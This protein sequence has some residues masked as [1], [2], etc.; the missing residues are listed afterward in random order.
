MKEL[1][2]NRCAFAACHRAFGGVWLVCVLHPCLRRTRGRQARPHEKTGLSILVRVVFAGTPEFAL[3]CLQALLAAEDVE[4]VGVVTQPDRRAGRGLRMLPSP[5]KR[6]ARAAGVEVITPRSLHGNPE[7]RAWLQGKRPD[8]LVVVAYGLLLPRAWLEAPRIAPINV[9]A[10]LLPR[11]RGAAPIERALLAGDAETGV[12]IMRMEE[13]LDCGGIY[14]RCRVAI[15]ETTT[16]AELR[17]ILAAAGAEL[18]IDSLPRILAGELQPEPQDESQATYAAKITAADRLIDWSEPAA[19]VDQRV[20]CFS[21]SPGA[22]TRL[23]GRW[24]KILRG[25][26][27]PD[28]IEG[29][30]PGE[31]VDSKRLVVVCGDRRLYRLRIVQPEGKKA[32]DAAAFVRG[33]ALSPESCFKSGAG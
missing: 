23:S 2:R 28:R 15:H 4:V 24:L 9:H 5:V 22:R 18:L 10:S 19:V 8:F 14:A 33:Y 13:G 12:S 3:P 29:R 1:H 21:P 30:S 25:E 6:A 7:A 31:I 27:L 11:W 20:R 16:G 17:Q 26:I 32:M